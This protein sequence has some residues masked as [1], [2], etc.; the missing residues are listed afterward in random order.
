VITVKI[1]KDGVILAQVVIPEPGGSV[2]V[3]PQDVTAKTLYPTPPSAG[4]GGNGQTGGGGKGQT[5]G[6]GNG[7]TGGGGNGQTGGGGNG[8]TGGGGNGQ[9]GRG[10]KWPTGGHAPYPV[11]AP[12]LHPKT[13]VISSYRI[14]FK[15]EQQEQSEW[16][17]A[18][19]AA[20]L[21]KFFDPCDVCSKRTLFQQCQI[22][23]R[24]LSPLSPPPPAP[25]LDCCGDP[26][27]CNI[28]QVLAEVLK[29]IGMWRTTLDRPL[30]FDEVQQEI[31]ADRP[32]CVRIEWPDGG[33]H[34]VVIRGYRVLASGA[35]QVYVADPL[36]PSSLVDFD[37]FTFSYYGDGKWTETELLQ[38]SPVD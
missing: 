22:A 15:I 38:T 34:A 1:D 37:E 26:T 13:R 12:G 17:W 31:D 36:Y 23:T 3:Y 14:R 18:A 33:G 19:V 29:A 9:T 5:G 10:G 28:P 4:G 7:Q 24:V 6:G 25:K 21:A 27:P 35:L 32:V 30:T 2:Q 8:Q 16:C 11:L 20:S